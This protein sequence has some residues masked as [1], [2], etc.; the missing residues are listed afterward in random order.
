VCVCV[1]QTSQSDQFK[2]VKATDFKC[3]MHASRDSLD[4]TFKNFSK[5]GRGQGPP[6]QL[7]LRAMVHVFRD[8]L[9]MTTM[10]YVSRGSGKTTF[11]TKHPNIMPDLIN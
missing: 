6:K 8:S 7:K 11:I 10:H 3:D 1:Q 9:D 4:M 5:R 2:T